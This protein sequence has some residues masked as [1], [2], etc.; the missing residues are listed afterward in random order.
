VGPRIPAAARV[1]WNRGIPMNAPLRGNLTLA[2]AGSVALAAGMAIASGAGLMFRDAVYPSRD[3]LQ[4]FWPNDVVNL[5]VGLPVLLASLWL[6]HRG[7]LAGLLLWPGALLYVLYNDLVP[8]FCMPLNMA[9][10]V[11]LVLVALSIYTSAAVVVS[12]D[13]AAV[14]ERLRG[15]V[16][17]KACGAIM[18][19]MGALFVLRAAGMLIAASLKGAPV[20][21][22]EVALNVTDFLI[23]PLWIIGGTLLWRRRALGY[24]AGLGLLFQCSMLF[25]GLILYMILQPFITGRPAAAVDV[26]VVLAMGLLF[27]VPFGLFLRGVNRGAKSTS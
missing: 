27:F 3:L 25:I 5:A 1:C 11:E 21:T 24:V 20:G 2:Y 8:L 23:T 7:V 12:I 10:L 26:L 4:T 16:H 18:A 9:F 15:R 19:V 22:P 17:E 14:R 6:A 13:G